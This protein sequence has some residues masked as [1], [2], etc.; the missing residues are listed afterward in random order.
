MT[1]RTALL[2]FGWLATAAFLPLSASAQE[3]WNP[4]GEDGPIRLPARKEPPR[5]AEPAKPYL[6]PMKGDPADARGSEAGDAGA[7]GGEPVFPQGSQTV[8]DPAS[9]VFAPRQSVESADLTPLAPPDAI[10]AG[11]SDAKALEQVLAALDVPS[12]SPAL[13]RLVRRTLLSPTG[14]FAGSAPEQVALRA[15]ALYRSGL[16]VDAQEQVTGQAPGRDATLAALS[17]RMMLATNNRERSCEA[18]RM[19]LAGQAS[20]PPPLKSDVLAVQGFCGAADGNLA[21]AGLAAALGREQRSIS[22]ETLAVL[23]AVAVGELPSW[24]SIKRVSVVD[25]RLAELAKPG[26]SAIPLE[27]AEPALLAA[28]AGDA[29]IAPRRRLDAAEAAA[30]L[31]VIDSAGLAAVYRQQSF[32]PEEMAQPQSARLEPSAR[33]ALLLKSA[34]AERTPAKKTR[35][36]RAMLDESRRAGLYL[37][38]AQMLA[39]A[40]EPLQPAVEIGWFA[41]TAVEV[42]L[43]AGRLERARGWVPNAMQQGAVAA[44]SG[45]LAHWLTL[46]DVADASGNQRRGESLPAVEELALRGRFNGESLH[47]LGAVLDALDYNVPVRLWDAASRGPQPSSGFLPPTGVLAELQEA[48]KRR[49]Q[50]RTPLL[51]IRALGPA[52]AE[53][54]HIIALGDAIRALKRCGLEADARQLAL[55]ALF[56]LWPRTSNT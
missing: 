8:G 25:Y 53:G 4:F 6:P 22:P 9:A 10:A 15:E 52:A 26:A 19:A 16:I 29:A 23:D 31:N 50:A 7:R 27:R 14:P 30:R 39:S 2:A 5:A 28:M 3:R 12:R 40:V 43:A 13:S 18:V 34:E 35:L 41:E 48:A 51:V 49:D 44:G 55:E 20:L 36:V 56:A 32:S 42:L 24:S 33:R 1:T 37:H 38:T 11:G 17:A 46:I 54:A 45:P 47:R 21:A